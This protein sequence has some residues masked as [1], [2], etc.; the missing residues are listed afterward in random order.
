MAEYLGGTIITDLTNTPFENYSQIDWAMYFITLYGQLDDVRY[1]ATVIDN[2]AR[3]LKGSKVVLSL[4]TWDNGES[5]Y[6][7][8]LIPSSEYKDWVNSMI[9][10]E[11]DVYPYNSGY[12]KLK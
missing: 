9:H 6:R 5:E 2:V 10:V 1:K 7:V 8:E 12:N 4:H 11:D 3:V